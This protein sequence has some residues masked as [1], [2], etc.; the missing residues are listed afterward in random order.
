MSLL[1]KN[2]ARNCLQAL[3]KCISR[4]VATSFLLMQSIS[5]IACI[6]GLASTL[7]VA[8]L[9]GFDTQPLLAE[10]ASTAIKMMKTQFG[11]PVAVE[12]TE[13]VSYN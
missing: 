6:Y 9:N 11:A 13:I 2:C 1:M 12:P 10:G 5:A 7:V 3:L 4:Q 8:F